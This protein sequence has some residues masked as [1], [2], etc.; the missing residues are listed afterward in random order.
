MNSRPST[1]VSRE[2]K[3]QLSKLM[4]STL[5]FQT[6]LHQD[7]LTGL[8]PVPSH[9]SRTKDNA[10]HAGLSPPLVP[11]RVSTGFTT[12]H[13]LLPLS[14]SN[15]WL[16]AH[17]CTE[18]KDAT[19]VSCKMPSSTSSTTVSTPKP[20]THTLPETRPARPRSVCSRSLVT[21]TFQREALLVWLTLT[22]PSQSLS[23]SMPRT[24]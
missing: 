4:P 23:P 13:R 22:W 19:E 16:T 15:N 17:G 20:P 18:T 5:T 10:V 9:Q 11:S 12:S 6:L 2:R 8:L 14:L 7:K 3:A 24:S 1:P 21:R